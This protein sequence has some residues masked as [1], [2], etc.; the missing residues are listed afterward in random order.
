VG[1]HGS[2]KTTA[3]AVALAL[4]L[5]AGAAA[6]VRSAE[7][8]LPPGQSGFVPP[9]GQPANP[10]L[11]DQVPLFESFAFKPAGFDKPGQVESPSA[12]VTITR[13]AYGVPNVRAGS[14]GDAWFGVGYAVAQDR[15]VELE[16]FRRSTQGRLAE[17]LGESRLQSDIVARRD[18]YTPKELRAQL[19]KLPARLRARFDAYAAGVNAWMA[20][21]AADPALRPR[22]FE[23]LGLVPK[24]WTALDSASV[25]VQLARTVP[26]D[27]G[28]ELGNWRA[29]RT[30]GAKRFARYLPLRRP[31]TPT[32]VPASTGRF[33]SQPGR[34]RADERRGYKASQR[35][36]KGL[37]PPKAGAAVAHVAGRLPARGGSFHFALRGPGNTASLFSAP[38]LG[39]SIPELFVEYEV[40][41]PGLD[42]RG[43]TGPGIPVTAAGHNG[44]IAWGITS[45]LG[46]EDDLYVERLAGKERYRFKGRTRKM[47]CR[48]ERFRVSG[49]KSVKR[50]FCR[51]VHGPVQARSG[52][53]AY[54][55]R[56]A[57]WGREL[58]T[59]VGLSALND[60]GSVR[61]ADAAA[62]KLTWNENLLVAD[63][64]GHIGWWHP[65]LLPLRPKRWDER[66]PLPGTGEAEWRGLLR[67]KA[68]PK[69][70]DPPQGYIGN[71]NNL[72]SVGWTQGDAPA[73]ETNEGNL[74]R[75]AFLQQVLR[76]STDRSLAGLKA[77][78]RRIGTTAQQRP[79]LDARLRAAQAAASG[80]ARTVLDT[81]VAW[82]GNYDRED[83][84][85]T[86]D[87]GVA[88]FEALKEAVEDTL[89][90]AAVTLLGQR[91]GSHPFD[92]GAAEA[93]GFHAV[94]T[95]G[96]VRAAGEA[97]RVL[98][99]RSGSADPAAWRQARKLYA[100][101]VQGVASPP[102]L[103]F[104][105][106]GTFSQAVKLG[107]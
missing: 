94:S 73:Q 67:V 34:S 50:R 97:Q 23:L 52:N 37:R 45:G 69:V 11:T 74:H 5:P 17:L 18:Y 1:S 6:G 80:P 98:V 59:F 84:N 39:F 95:A 13:D 101:Q 40:H 76:E 29:L 43:V 75:G 53:R 96:L 55:R 41:A 102:R 105:D 93:A 92:M 70:I 91:G 35:F 38:Q 86:V 85:G 87:P 20:R 78:E 100:V 107:P 30:L 46:D 79:L 16:L 33:P 28:R 36:L 82:D 103:K 51:T 57:I 21:V 89:P 27:D 26:S 22:E 25:G 48:N 24:P 72:P 15:L 66:L 83:S 104:Y 32:T 68:R 49:A 106:R 47:S 63:D 58:Q 8:V 77:I 2:W 10:H 64:G 71:W 7:S 54:A 60:A 14:A 9:E 19:R 81:I 88:A 12:G 44:R 56:Y 65:G 99:A 3:A 90:A 31:G 42:V 62:A 4:A 61:E